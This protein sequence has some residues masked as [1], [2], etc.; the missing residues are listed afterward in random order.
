MISKI[1]KVLKLQSKCIVCKFA[2]ILSEGLIVTL[3]WI[4]VDVPLHDYFND[5]QDCQV[6]IDSDSTL[7]RR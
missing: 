3:N 6:S 4:L 2:A 1:E 5:N 7:N